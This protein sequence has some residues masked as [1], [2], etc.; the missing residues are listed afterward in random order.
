VDLDERLKTERECLVDECG[1][2][3]PEHPG[4]EED[5][6][7]AER[8]GLHELA[9][10]DDE[11]LPEDRHRDRT[12]HPDEILDASPEKKVGSVSTESPVAPAATNSPAI[13]SGVQPS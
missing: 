3:A 7:G 4:D 11:V 12:P 1:E 13:D 8:P 9:F 10:V 6:I 2:A 5:G